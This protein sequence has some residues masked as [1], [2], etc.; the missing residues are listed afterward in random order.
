MLVDINIIH[1]ELH[2]DDVNNDHNYVYLSLNTN[3]FYI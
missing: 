2:I 1:L 3:I